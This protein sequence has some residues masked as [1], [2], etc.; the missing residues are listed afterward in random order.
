ME[1][2]EAVRRRR[3]TRNFSGQP[4]PPGLLDSMLADA[5][6][7]PSAGNTQGREFVVLDGPTET[8]RYWDATTDDDWRSAS[9]RFEGMARAPVVVLPFVDPDAYAS[10]YRE[11]DKTQGN[12]E[13]IEWVVPFWFVDAAYAVMTLLL[14]AADAGIGGAF[15]GNFRGETALRTALGVPDRYRWLGAVL[16]GEA[17]EPDPPSSSLSRPKR[18]MAEVVH[19]GR[20]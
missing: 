6:R 19:R 11:A 17:S 15:L 2:S 9:R 16:L 10:R 5:L 18:P 12:G 13:E 1:L 8:R 3:M 4:L 7:A 14:R 20:W